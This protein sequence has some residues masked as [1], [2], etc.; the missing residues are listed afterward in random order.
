M[1]FI[2]QYIFP[3][4]LIDIILTQGKHAPPEYPPEYGGSQSPP[5]PAMRNQKKV[6]CV[7]VSCFKQSEHV[8]FWPHWTVINTQCLLSAFAKFCFLKVYWD[9]GLYIY[10]CTHSFTGRCRMHFI[11]QFYLPVILINIILTWQTGTTRI[12]TWVWWF[13]VTACTF[14]G[15]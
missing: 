1:Y 6:N 3:C 5:V 11:E 9:L 14:Y 15:K 7:L 8:N 4:I 10:I 2:D 13:T 12:P